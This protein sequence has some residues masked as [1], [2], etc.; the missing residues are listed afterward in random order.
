[1]A[2]HWRQKCHRDRWHEVARRHARQELGPSDLYLEDGEDDHRDE[3]RP[4][5][6]Q[7]ALGEKSAGNESPYF[8]GVKIIALVFEQ[9]RRP[10]LD[11]AGRVYQ[12]RQDEA[13]GSQ[14]E[15][16]WNGPGQ[17]AATNAFPQRPE[18]GPH[19][20]DRGTRDAVAASR[21]WSRSHPLDLSIRGERRR[22]DPTSRQ[23]A[24][25]TR[26]RVDCARGR[27]AAVVL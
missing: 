13:G 26:S 25:V 16:R 22:H 27:P 1:M 10:L 4:Q 18:M 12:G 17:A 20:C 5:I 24:A 6:L 14:G 8:A 21:C 7:P 11:R 19:H 9:A 15:T 3:Q 2:D 23:H